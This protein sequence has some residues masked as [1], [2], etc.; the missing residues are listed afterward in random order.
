MQQ[1]VDARK[2][3]FVFTRFFF[4][5]YTFYFFNRRPRKKFQQ[6]EIFLQKGAI[7]IGR[8]QIGK[9]RNKNRL[10]LETIFNT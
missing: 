8:N 6:F 10:R 4:F 3:N 9:R 5:L 7:L 1:A 2:Y